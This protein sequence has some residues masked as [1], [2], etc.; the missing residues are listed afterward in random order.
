[1]I[2]VTRRLTIFLRFEVFLLRNV[3]K[4]FFD[5]I[6]LKSVTNF[7]DVFVCLWGSLVLKM[8]Y[9]AFEGLLSGVFDS[10]VAY[11]TY[12]QYYAPLRVVMMSSR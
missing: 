5:K 7:Q 8:A 9:R 1:M 11:L 4:I 10:E 12:D 6:A 2:V 3:R